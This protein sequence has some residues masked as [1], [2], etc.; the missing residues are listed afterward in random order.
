M[1]SLF[2]CGVLLL[3]LSRVCSERR[4]FLSPLALFFGGTF[5]LFSG[6]IGG[7]G[8]S[9]SLRDQISDGHVYTVGYVTNEGTAGTYAVIR[10]VNTDNVRFV[11]L[12]QGLEKLQPRAYI[13]KDGTFDL[14]TRVVLAGSGK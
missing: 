13:A 9:S 14:D 5:L 3:V 6:T 12:P 4:P 8:T 10:E 2:V 1:S 7:S 11:E